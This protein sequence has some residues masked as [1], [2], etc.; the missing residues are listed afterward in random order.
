MVDDCLSAMHGSFDYSKMR[1]DL[2]Q[3]HPYVPYRK[4]HPDDARIAV[5]AAITLA[6]ILLNYQFALPPRKPRQ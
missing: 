4:R 3:N 2:E 6:A 5:V 1:C